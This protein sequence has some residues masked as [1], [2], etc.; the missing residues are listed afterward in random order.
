MVHN[1]CNLSRRTIV[2]TNKFK[3]DMV[4][5]FKSIHHWEKLEWLAETNEMTTERG[6][7]RLCLH[8]FFQYVE[9]GWKSR[10]KNRTGVCCCASTDGAKAVRV[11]AS[12]R[13]WKEW[14]ANG[15]KNGLQEVYLFTGA[16]EKKKL[17]WR[18]T[19]PVPPRAIGFCSDT[20]T[21]ARGSQSQSNCQVWNLHVVGN[22]LL[23]LTG[24][25]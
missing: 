18:G 2:Q 14:K 1:Q 17:D 24:H 22:L 9:F 8:L 23:V 10:Q 11:P 13:W 12:G 25:F 15:K 19:S 20:L 3:G 7:G 5:I 21:K 16:R 4:S 6:P